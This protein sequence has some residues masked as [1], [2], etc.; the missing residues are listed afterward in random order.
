[1]TPVDRDAAAELADLEL[2]IGETIGCV[3]GKQLD[4]AVA[5]LSMTGV[6]FLAIVG[7]PGERAEVDS[8]LV[9]VL[10]AI[11]ETLDDW[12]RAR[13]GSTRCAEVPFAALDLLGHRVGAAIE[14]ARRSGTAKSAKEGTT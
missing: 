13:S 12:S 6:L 10:R 11:R 7:T 9:L 8:P 1:M 14:I 2:A 3:H 5:A 4:E